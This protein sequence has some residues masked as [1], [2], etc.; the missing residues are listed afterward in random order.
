VSLSLRMNELRQRGITALLAAMIM[1]PLL[2]SSSNQD[3]RIFRPIVC[4]AL[5][6]SLAAFV[7]ASIPIPGKKKE[8]VQFLRSGPN[9]PVVLLV[10]YGAIS[11]CCSPYPQFSGAEWIRLACGAAL[12]FVIAGTLRRRSQ[13]KSVVHLLIALAGLTSLFG[14]VRYGMTNESS[15]S[16]F[17]MNGQLCSGFLLIQ[18][19]LVLVLAFAGNSVNRKILARATAIL[20]APALLLTQTRSSWLGM[21]AAMLLLAA[22]AL[23][24]PKTRRRLMRQK[25]QVVP[26]LAILIGSL[27][28]F[29]VVTRTSTLVSLRAHTLSS[30]ARDASFIWRLRMWKGAWELI[31]E[32]P[33]LGWGIGTFPLEQARTIPGSA[34]QALVQVTGPTLAQDAHN[35]YAQVAAEMGIAGLGL[36]LWVLGAFFISG[37]RAACK[38]P[39]GLRKL[40]LLGCLAGVAA[41]SVDALS[42]PAWRF[43]DVSFMFWLM[44]G[45]GMAVTHATSRSR[46]DAAAPAPAVPPRRLYRLGWQTA[47]LVLA[48]VTVGGTWA[49]RGYSPVPV[50]TEAIQLNIQPSTITLQPGQCVDFHVTADS[51]SATP[52]DLTDSPDTRL[53]TH[54]GVEQCLAGQAGAGKSNVFCVPQ[55]ACSAPGCGGDRTVLVFATYGHPQVTATARVRISC[56]IVHDVAITRLLVAPLVSRTTDAPVQVTVVNRGTQ[57]EQCRLRL[58]VQPGRM[59]V[60]DAEVTLAAGETKTLTLTWPT[61]LMGDDGPKSLAAELILEGFEDS[62]PADNQATQLVT[63]GP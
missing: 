49:Q 31:R 57:T 13:V 46:R 20:I 3:W 48:L 51:G 60:A 2:F 23:R 39:S 8:I 21:L 37:Y 61:P 30:P 44:L 35:E 52:T 11:W 59:I 15:L 10:L 27:G 41:Q 12:Y 63:V 40:V 16:A 6:L 17:F 29:L 42:N 24:E 26:P 18:T 14:L 19:P 53:F 58:R 28:L 43:A 4:E 7:L 50:Y 22:I 9:L 36:D 34:P 33:L 62:Q 32:R 38:R 25:H 56:P 1:A 47:S 55:D 54:A 45:L 5:V